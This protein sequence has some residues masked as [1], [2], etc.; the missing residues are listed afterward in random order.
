MMGFVKL[1]TKAKVSVE[2][3]E[4][5]QAQFLFDIKHLPALKKYLN[6]LFSTGI[7]QLLNMSLFQI[8]QQ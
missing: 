2:D 7:N 1:T 3:F 5:L 6:A 8:G 4:K